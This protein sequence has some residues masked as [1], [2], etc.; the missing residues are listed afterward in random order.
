MRLRHFFAV[1]VLLAAWPVAAAAPESFMDC[2]TCP[3]MVVVP[4]GSFMMGVAPG[5]QASAKQSPQH[6]VTFAKPFAVGKYDVTRDEYSVFVEATNRRDPQSCEIYD[7]NADRRQT[8]GASW[9]NP[10]FMQ[11]DRDPVV[12]VSWDDANAYAAWLSMKTSKHYRLLSES[13]WEYAARAGS[14]DVRYGAN[15]DAQLCGYINLGDRDYFTHFP[16]DPDVDREC[17]DGYVFTSPVGSFAPNAFG[18]YDMLGNVWQWTADCDNSNYVGA[19]SDGSTWTTGNCDV[20]IGRGGAWTEDAFGVR[21]V[22]RGQGRAANHGSNT[23][24]RVARDM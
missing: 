23:G 17:S 1:I 20:R 12:C 14:T 16:S 10:G 9:R 15:A 11:G 6:R 4:A 3:E 2:E 21:T 22:T 7:D 19:P 18:L 13:E 5:Q 8:P 24:F